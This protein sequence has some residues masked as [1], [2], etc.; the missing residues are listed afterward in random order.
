LLAY[1]QMALGM[2]EYRSGHYEAA[3]DALF[4]AAELAENNDHVSATT[5]FYRAMSLFKLGKAAEAR[6]LA[7]EAA[8][9]MK[10]AP[11]DEKNPLSGNYPTDVLILWMAFK[12][13]FALLGLTR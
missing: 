12:E 6:K 8:F 2:A 10:Y 9:R 3:D 5:A 11:A 1:F 4:A 7:F 13:A